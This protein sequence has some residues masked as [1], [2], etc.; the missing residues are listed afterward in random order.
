MASI[1]LKVNTDT[2]KAESSIK[3]FSKTTEKEAK[4]IKANL[5][6]WKNFES[7]SFIKKNK[8][9]ALS[10]KQTVS[11]S[12]ALKTENKGLQRK[13][14]MLIRNGINPQDKALEQLQSEYKRTTR[15][16]K[17]NAKAQKMNARIAK[18]GKRAMI[19]LGLAVVGVGA[20]LLKNANDT[21]KRADSFAKFARTI[22]I[23]IEELQELNFVAN[24]AGISQTEMSKG[25]QKLNKN[26]G[27]LRA[28]LGSMNQIL[29][30]QDP[31][32]L[33]Q[34]KNAKNSNEA[35]DIM[36][37]KLA[38]M[39]SATDRAALATAA[40]GKIGQKFLN[41][42][43]LGAA[44]IAEL[45]KEAH[46][47]GIIS[48]ASAKNSEDYM[49]SQARLQAAFTGVKNVLGAALIPVI[50]KVM[51]FFTEFLGDT[52]RLK[53]IF[54]TWIPIIAGVAGA[55][56]GMM[57][58][59]KIIAVIKGFKTSMLALK[60]VL[61]GHPIF[62]LVGVISLLAIAFSDSGRSIKDF[63][64]EISTAEKTSRILDKQLK[65]TSS[66]FITYDKTAKVAAKGSEAYSTSVVNLLKQSPELK[67]YGVT[68]SS[69]YK[70]VT[71]AQ[72]LMTDAL[73]AD[74]IIKA[75]EQFNKL[76]DGLGELKGKLIQA[77]DEYKNDPTQA[78]LANAKK[79]QALLK[80]SQVAMQN[81]G[82][83]SGRSGAEVTKI[84]DEMGAKLGPLTGMF[85]GM[86]SE[87]INGLNG[88]SLSSGDLVKDM[89]RIFNSV[90]LVKV[91]FADML[92]KSSGKTKTKKP[93]AITTKFRAIGFEEALKNNQILETL[94]DA[95][96]RKV[97][98]TFEQRLREQ[99]KFYK[100]S[101]GA[102]QTFF[103]I[104]ETRTKL[105]FSGRPI[106]QSSMLETLKKMKESLPIE[107]YKKL[108][109]TQKKSLMIKLKEIQ[110]M[111]ESQRLNSLQTELVKINNL[112]SIKG[113]QRIELA[114]V[115]QAKITEIQA[116]ESQKRMANIT[117]TAQ[118]TLNAFSGI[119]SALAG[120]ATAESAQKIA[121]LDQQF[122]KEISGRQLTDKQKEKLQKD[123]DKKKAKIEFAGAMRAWNLERAAAI[124][125][126]ASAVISA[127]QTK[128]F[129][130][131]G[132]A[133]AAVAATMAGIQI[134]TVN[135]GKPT[136][137]AETG[138]NFIVPDNPG[139]GRVDS[140]SLRVNPGEE[141]QVNPRG[142]SSG[143][144][145]VLN[146]FIDKQLIYSIVQN[147]VDDGEITFTNEN[148]VAY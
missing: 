141:I 117:K 5:D 100:L 61:K 87:A 138:G 28:G 122:E 46:K 60:V 129:F 43:E 11:A 34:L 110:K 109:E 98:S 23:T 37:K 88:V 103:D 127:L 40:F 31:A 62:L 47:Y 14:Q 71:E 68:A 48:T 79:Y 84:F 85:N 19:G 36:I 104:V 101:G 56:I 125:G 105:A 123:F 65:L 80:R 144:Q 142:E 133:A 21:A 99:L 94:R 58:I 25:L 35:F 97:A 53:T 108:I 38:G 54:K 134:A 76:S 59:T 140:Q 81:L 10:V 15:Q 27:D 115:V 42:S 124:A 90:S 130:P 89:Q 66:A 7:D 57:I 75:N 132:I 126:G 41:V 24:I 86:T 111:P 118:F 2:S 13:M 26:V 143:K 83:Q 96:T 4:R 69:S 137:S 9:I 131:A 30:K 16:M 139:S 77:Y 22:G 120:F 102:A 6:K 147:G 82:K 116:I 1:G 52:E 39:E 114:K 67:K 145:M 64:N 112:E 49:D 63:E 106:E 121:I 70:Q 135:K 107:E 50:K 78:N 12:A 74:Q 93:K 45:R 72:K 73:K 55:L 8:R 92:K 33:A 146:N 113:E 3:N 18:V 32:L 148:L 20:A 119:S 17:V 29:K 128:P 91:N 44:K 95:E 136:L 51:D